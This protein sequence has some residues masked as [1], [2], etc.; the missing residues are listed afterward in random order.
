MMWKFGKNNVTKRKKQMIFIPEELEKSTEEILNPSRGWYTIYPFQI[1]KSIDPEELKWCLRDKESI[2]LVQPDLGAYAEKPLDFSALNNIKS[3]LQFFKSYEKD[4]ILRPVYDLEGKGMEHEPDNLDL[5]LKH[6]EQIGMLLKEAEHSVYLFQGMLIGSWGEMHTSRYASEDVMQKLYSCIRHCLG[7]DIPL[8][9]RTPAIWRSLI[10][11]EKYEQ[12]QYFHTGLFH[13]AMFASTSDMGT[14]GVMTREAAGWKQSWTRSEEIRFMSCINEKIAYGGEV[15]A[16]EERSMQSMISEMRRLHVNYLN[17]AYDRKRLDE[18]KA[19]AWTGEDEYHGQSGYD[20]VGAHLGYRFVV[21]NPRQKA[22]HRMAK[23]VEVEFTIEN[24]GF[25]NCPQEAE[26]VVR[27]EH[28]EAAYED[29]L[30]IDLKDV[31]SGESK[32]VAVLLPLIE[33]KVFLHAFRKKDKR[34]I[35]FANKNAEPL[36]LGVL[37]L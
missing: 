22:Y 26:L 31:R 37:H 3:I 30:K 7:E 2:A 32:V 11:E 24:V 33:G 6:M 27:V 1:E 34:K 16:G 14:Y 19:A 29:T 10:E 8:A 36:L 35:H 21:S 23:K 4:V 20:Y 5:V 12:K 25:G 9:V 17:R 15:L 18:W 13:D 28:G